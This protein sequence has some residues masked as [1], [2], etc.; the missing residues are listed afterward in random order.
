MSIEVPYDS[1]IFSTPVIVKPTPSAQDHEILRSILTSAVPNEMTRSYFATERSVY[2]ELSESP[3]PN[4]S[5]GR[6]DDQNLFV[7]PDSDGTVTHVRIT[8]ERTI[9]EKTKSLFD[10]AVPSKRTRRY[11][12]TG[13]GLFFGS[14]MQNTSG[15]SESG[16]EEVVIEDDTSTYS[17]TEQDM[18]NEGISNIDTRTNNLSIPTQ[19]ETSITRTK[20]GRFLSLILY[21]SYSPHPA[22]R[23]EEILSAILTFPEI[24]SVIIHSIQDG[25][26]LC[27]ELSSNRTHVLEPQTSNEYSTFTMHHRSQQDCIYVRTRPGLDDEVVGKIRIIQY[28]M[29]GRVDLTSICD[30]MLKMSM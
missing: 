11:K 8:L 21:A 27:I 26:P 15:G 25:K 5:T 24:D 1:T 18:N 10:W 30:W 12:I 7:A 23:D 22:D 14:V 3:F 13:Q 6:E 28:E 4:I 16:G 29:V 19:Q 20:R 2:V 9:G 17:Q